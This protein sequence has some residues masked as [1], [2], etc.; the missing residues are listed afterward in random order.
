MPLGVAS[1]SW[2][3]GSAP[4]VAGT[5]AGEGGEGAREIEAS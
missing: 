3:V 5:W 1:V 4:G 2:V